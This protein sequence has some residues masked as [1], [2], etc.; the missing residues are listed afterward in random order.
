MPRELQRKLGDVY[1]REMLY[2]HGLHDAS[3]PQ[4]TFIRSKAKCRQ[5]VISCR[6]SDIV[7][8]SCVTRMKSVVFLPL[9]FQVVCTTCSE[10][11]GKKGK[12]PC[13]CCHM[14]IEE[15][16]RVFVASC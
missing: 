14:P 10:G 7:G 15:R 9:A 2:D 16:I 12:A 3:L 11:Y 4:W 1:I 8:A 6:C 5:L 13:P